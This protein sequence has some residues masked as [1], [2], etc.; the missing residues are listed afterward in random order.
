MSCAES[1]VTESVHSEESG[2]GIIQNDEFAKDVILHDQYQD[3]ISKLGSK[4]LYCQGHFGVPAKAI[5]FIM[6]S[7]KE[8]SLASVDKCVKAL[9][10]KALNN[11]L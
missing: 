6:E 2:N 7:L 11:Q 10:E 5:D 1:T 4:L 3:L 8:I 9:E